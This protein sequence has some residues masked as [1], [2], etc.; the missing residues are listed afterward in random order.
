MT[1]AAAS[2]AQAAP[3]DQPEI[4]WTVLLLGFAGMVIGQFMA[5]RAG[6]GA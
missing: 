1:D 4:N 2:S 3:A 5:A 6:V